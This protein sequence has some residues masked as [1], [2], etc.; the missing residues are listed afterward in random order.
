MDKNGLF[1]SF[2]LFA[3][4]KPA[5]WNDAALSSYTEQGRMAFA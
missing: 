2:N 5:G 1:V 3:F 4:V